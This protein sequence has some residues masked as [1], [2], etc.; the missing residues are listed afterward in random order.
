MNRGMSLCKKLMA[1]GECEICRTIQGLLPFNSTAP[2][3]GAVLTTM[4]ESKQAAGRRPVY[5]K[6]LGKYLLR[7]VKGRETLPVNEVTTAHVEDYLSGLTGH[8]RATHLNRI[9]TLFAFAVKRA[10]IEVNPCDRIERTAIDRRTPRI[11]TP[12]QARRLYAIC[13]EAVRPYLTLCLYAGI[14]PD[15]CHRLTWADVDLD[16]KRVV[17]G[18]AQSKVRARRVVP[19]P[20]I[21]VELLKKHPKQEGPIT[22]SVSTV[23]RFKRAARAVVGE[24]Q[25]DILRH[26][27]ISYALAHHEDLGKVATWMGTS[28]TVIK[29]H[30][31]A[32]AAPETA[33]EFFALPAP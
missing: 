27:A 2:S 20:D 12:D 4:L 22:P 25:A 13:P 10:H 19:L 23:R 31:D 3:L 33:R 21:A 29:R 8:N 9:S 14:R 7:F 24:W 15:E 5:V 18:E 28:P 26:T 1:A 6:S 30:Y 17:I 32:V 11:L 16:N